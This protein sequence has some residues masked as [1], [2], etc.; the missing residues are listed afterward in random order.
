MKKAI[1]VVMNTLNTDA[2]VQRAA[3]AL[4]EQFDLTVIATDKGTNEVGYNQVLMKTENTTGFLRYLKFC[5][6]VKNYFKKSEFDLFY[7]HD[8]YSAGLVG[9]VHKKFPSVKIVYD[10]HELCMPE[11]GKKTGV[12]DLFFYN[13][14]KWNIKKPNLVI[15]ATDERADIMQRHYG[16][17][18]KPLPI[19]NISE[20]TIVDDDFA[21]QLVERCDDFLKSSETILVYAGVLHPGRK[22]D[23]LFGI[24]E[25][26][27]STNLLIVGGGSDEVRLKKLAEERIPGRYCFTGSLPYSYMGVLLSRCDVGYISYPTNNQNNIY[28]APNKIYEYASVN[29]PMI[30]PENPTI[31][32]FF[33]EYGIGIVDND[34]SFA[35]G[36]VIQNLQM[37]KDRCKQFTQENSWETDAKKLSNAVQGLF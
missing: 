13:N 17:S 25:K 32:K 4:K 16:L 23:N 34:L 11:K 31:R 35:F 19:Q 15:C 10:A 22:I 12:R 6:F 20:L 37:H 21:R 8:Y 36:K 33:E 7:A 26:N 30:A 14:E 27:T 29:L 3:N 5:K 28:C 2:R 24:I 18:Q 9:W 1:M